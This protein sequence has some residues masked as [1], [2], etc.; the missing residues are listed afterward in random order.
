MFVHFRL[1]TFQAI[2]VNYLVC[3]ITGVVFIGDS[4]L[5]TKIDF[6][7]TWV[8]LALALGTIFTGTFNLMAITTQKLGI[9]VASVA[10]KMS[11]IIPVVMSIFVFNIHSKEHTFL[12]F[13]GIL[14]AMVAI[15]LSSMKKRREG[16]SDNIL[17]STIM[18]FLLPFG[19]FLLGGIIDSSINYINYKFITPDLEA[20]FPIV[21]F[22]SAFL[23]GGFTLVIKMEG[24]NMR[25]A[26]GGLVLGI[27]NYFSFYFLVKGLTSFENDGALVYPI[28]SI[29]IILFSSFFSVFLFKEKLLKINKIGLLLAVLSVTLIFY[30][31]IMEYYT[32]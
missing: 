19:V 18:V 5:L 28:F 13:F 1:N 26:L 14:L 8:I 17:P 32:H 20:I 27:I 30:Q 15:V 25:S 22:A 12:N 21:T 7:A 10:S 6:S 29:G 24:I 31:E 16:R 3:V 9:T 23:V 11:L 4:Q 2:V